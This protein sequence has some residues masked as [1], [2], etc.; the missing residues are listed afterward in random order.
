MIELLTTLTVLGLSIIVLVTLITWLNVQI[1]RYCG[2]EP[3]SD[4]PLPKEWR[5]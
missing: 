4:E 5:R 3:E 2:G 1:D